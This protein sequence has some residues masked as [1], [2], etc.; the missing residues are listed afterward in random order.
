MGF[1]TII[2]VH[3][4]CTILS[5]GYGFGMV[6]LQGPMLGVPAEIFVLGE[7]VGPQKATVRIEYVAV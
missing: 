7:R 3:E 6:W 5:F 4:F 2:H 1:N